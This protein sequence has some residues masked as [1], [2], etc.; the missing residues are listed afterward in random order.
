MNFRY[1]STHRVKTCVVELS[2]HRGEAPV[3][4][5][6][7]QLYCGKWDVLRCKLMGEIREV[8]SER[9]GLQDVLGNG[10]E[11]SGYWVRLAAEMRTGQI[12]KFIGGLIC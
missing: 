8:G 1:N 12:A 5:I 4:A 10:W 9:F 2:A 3:K 6:R 7:W 11:I